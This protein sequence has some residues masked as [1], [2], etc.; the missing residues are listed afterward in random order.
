MKKIVSF[1]GTDNE[2]FRML[3]TRAKEYALTKDLDYRW[4]IQEPF[5]EENVI[6]EL[7]DADAGIIDIQPYGENIFPHICDSAKL[8]IR[9]G[10]GYDKVDL[11]A[12]S[13][14]GIA[15][16]R[17]TG[18]NTNAVS[19]MALTL[20]LACA[21]MIPY[22]ASLVNTGEWTK[23]SITN[24][25]VGATVGIV[26]FGAIGQAF[27]KLAKG[28]GCRVLVYNPTPRPEI[29]EE[30]GV[31]L[32]DI[33]TLFKESDGISVHCAYNESTHHLI[34]R[35]LLSLMKPTA[36]LVNTARGAIIDDDALYE[37]LKARS[38]RGAGLDV[39]CT[40]PLPLDSR[41]FELDNIILT[42]HVSGQTLESLW[43][44]YSMAIDIAADFF[45][46]K[47]VKHILNPDYSTK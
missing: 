19:E 5:S 23:R 29:A 46:G 7:N 8:L 18:A 34:G 25:I 31:E 38:I 39:F 12:A 28:L 1:F 35:H 44:I 9:F 40:E 20:M 16:A 33:E 26:G 43:N 21:R 24:E 27:A 2:M 47:E 13:R 3:N 6:T 41:Y 4:V 37:T 30:I 17:T 45:S 11:K 22:N 42:P 32:V 14:Y 15:V 36:V 10:V